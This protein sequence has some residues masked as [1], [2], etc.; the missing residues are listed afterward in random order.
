MNTTTTAIVQ[1]ATKWFHEDACTA[2]SVGLYGRMRELMANGQSQRKASE[3]MSAECGEKLTAENIRKRFAYHNSKQP[4]AL[5]KTSHP[6]SDW[7][8]GKKSTNQTSRSKL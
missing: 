4:S 3:Q 6:A 8:A 1:T 7:P 5:G 2:C